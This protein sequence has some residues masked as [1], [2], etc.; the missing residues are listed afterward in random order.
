MTR[1]IIFLVIDIGSLPLI[2]HTPVIKIQDDDWS[3]LSEIDDREM[4]APV[5]E[6]KGAAD[7]KEV[8]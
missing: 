6:C 5:G 3:N 4:V 1:L 7:A 2:S 8:N